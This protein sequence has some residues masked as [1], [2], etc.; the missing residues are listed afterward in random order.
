MALPLS[1]PPL[2]L[3]L[4]PLSPFLSLHVFLKISLQFQTVSSALKSRSAV[5]A[6]R[7]VCI[8]LYA[9]NN[10]T[11]LHSPFPYSRPDILELDTLL[12]ELSLCSARTE[13][14]FRF[15][16]RKSEVRHLFKAKSIS[17]SVGKR[18]RGKGVIINI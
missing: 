9:P 15:L 13:L 12:T 18:M 1:L 5:G 6:I 16:R 2:S 14:Y 7:Y 3:S 4:P 11:I 8:I 17:Y 10:N